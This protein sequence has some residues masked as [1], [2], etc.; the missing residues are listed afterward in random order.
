MQDGCVVCCALGGLFCRGGGRRPTGSQ[1][2]LLREGSGQDLGPLVL[3]GM[4]LR[5]GEITCSSKQ[6][7]W[8]QCVIN[9]RLSGSCRVSDGPRSPS[10]MA[11]LLRQVRVE[12]LVGTV[13]SP[14]FPRLETQVCRFKTQRGLYWSGVKGCSL[15]FDYPHPLTFPP[16]PSY[17]HE[18]IR[19][20]L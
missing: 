1:V 19:L 14:P 20:Q 4:V 9:Q 17:F 13:H 7:C 5:F 8:K 18:H 10:E 16:K 6:A 3:I 11:L 12:R 2:S 15:A